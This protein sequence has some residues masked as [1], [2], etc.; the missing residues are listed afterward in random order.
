MSTVTFSSEKSS[1]S[2]HGDLFILPTVKQS[3][4]K[5][6]SNFK[7]PQLSKVTKS[8]LSL[9]RH[10]KV[11]IVNSLSDVQLRVKGLRKVKFQTILND[12]RMKVHLCW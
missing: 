7:Q 3:K 6:R 4:V 2:V 11:S 9:V 8:R 10:Q 12:I 5:E 1:K